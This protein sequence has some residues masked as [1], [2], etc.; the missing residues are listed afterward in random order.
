MS[1]TLADR[2]INLPPYLFEAIDR[3]KREAV[4]AGVDLIDVSI[5]DPDIPTPAHIVKSMKTA[6]GNPEHHRYPSSVGM[7]GFRRA[8]AG[9]YKTRFGV[10]IAPENEVVTLIGSKE[11]IGHL[12]LAFVNPGDVVLYTSPGYPVYPIGPM[13]AGGEGYP[14]PLRPENDFLPDL[15]SIPAD[16]L[17]RAKLFF[18]NYPNNPTA[19]CATKAFYEEVVEFAS[20]H[21]IIAC[22]DAAYSEIYYDGKK[23]MSFL[24]VDGAKEVG[25]EIH[26]LSKT[27]NMT[28][29]RLGFAVG[30]KDVVGGLA[31]IK[32]NIDSG[33]FQAVQEA[34]IT[35]LGSDDSIL[36]P[37]RNI[38]EER[39]NALADGLKKLGLEFR[40][41]EASF[42][43][44]AKVPAGFTSTSFVELLL[45][46]AGIMATPGSGF[47]EAGEGYVRFAL[48]VTA[49]RMR[50]AAARMASVI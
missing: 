30:H 37:I 23:P 27:Y 38:Y 14:L 46:K 15:K 6:V 32:S 35:A 29:W 13:F 21:N 34:G 7:L 47:G 4:A 31:K 49:N 40:M 17:K 1:V 50:E 43:I 36:L 41:P 28:G 18:F 16:V 39:R 20:R 2:L 42:Y 44:W 33:A 9:W 45:N 3:M 24:E 19:A 8:V 10:D 22:H 26:S 12:P 25:I 48:T 5:G 11:G